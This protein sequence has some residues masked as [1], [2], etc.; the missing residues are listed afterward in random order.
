MKKFHIKLV[1]QGHCDERGAGFAAN[2]VRIA[3]VYGRGIVFLC[4]KGNTLNIHDTD[5]RDALDVMYSIEL[6]KIKDL[7]WRDSLF[8]GVLKFT[9]EGK[10]YKFNQLCSTSTSAKY[11]PIRLKDFTT[12]YFETP[13]MTVRERNTPDNIA[14]G[15]SGKIYSNY[16]ITEVRV[17]I[18]DS[19]G[20]E[21]IKLQDFPFTVL[22]YDVRYLDLDGSVA[23]LPAGKYHYELEVAYAEEK[24][25]CV[26]FDFTK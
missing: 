20:K 21:V 8:F 12:G 1:E 22:F 23:K 25:T 3:D 13:Y 19:T 15:L 5:M 16:Q 14:N 2:V 11:I 24:P 6:S 18:T 7:K 17:T 26:S 4:V 9:Y 10:K